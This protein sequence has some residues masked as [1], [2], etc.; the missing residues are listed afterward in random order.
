MTLKIRIL[1][2]MASALALAAAIAACSQPTVYDI[3]QTQ[4]AQNKID[5]DNATRQ[6]LSD[7]GLDPDNPQQRT[8]GQGSV[9]EQQQQRVA[10]TQTAIA[11]A[12]GTLAGTPIPQSGRDIEVPDGPALTDAD[13]PTVEIL[14]AGK[15]EPEIIKVAVGTTVTWTNERRSASTSTSV[16]GEAEQWDS[17]NLFKGTFATEAASFSHTFTIPGC[18]R[19]QSL[20]SGDTSSGA[21]CVVEQ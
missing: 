13:S 4:T 8:V 19:Y 10:A 18:H 5:N 7:A 3:V 14:V 6:A 11:A 17:G 16:P 21:V 20:Q 9:A 15:F 1:L 12:G 2:V